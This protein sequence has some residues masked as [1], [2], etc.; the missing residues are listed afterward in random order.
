[1][2]VRILTRRP[3]PWR[4]YSAPLGLVES[5]IAVGVGSSSEVGGGV[6]PFWSRDWNFADTA[7]MRADAFYYEVGNPPVLMTESVS[8]ACP[9]GKYVQTSYPGSGEGNVNFDHQIPSGRREVWIRLFHRYLRWSQTSDDKSFFIL[10]EA[11]GGS[12]RWEIHFSSPGGTGAS[13]CMANQGFY[14]QGVE[15][16]TNVHDGEWHEILLHLKMST[17]AST[18][19]GAFEWKVDDE[20]ILTARNINTGNAPGDNFGYLRLGANADPVGV[21]P[22]RDLGLHEIYDEKPATGFSWAA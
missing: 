19:D 17:N 9:A 4:R 11:F 15:I 12:N 20:V 13:Y 21:N 6:E 7:A 16:S 18:S 14:E 8:A 2:A 1:M 5:E 10:N 22:K 3:P